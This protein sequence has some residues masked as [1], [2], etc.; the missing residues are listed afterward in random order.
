MEPVT[1][2]VTALALGAAAGLKDTAE[3]AIKDGYAALKSLVQHKY[4][5]VDLAQLEKAP[6]STARRAVVTEELEAAGAVRDQEILRQAQKLI[7]EITAQAPETAAAIGV[8][9]EDIKAASLTIEDVIASGTGAKVKKA[10]VAG[11]VTIKGIR[12][13]QGGGTP[14][15]K[16]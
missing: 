7:D 4:A 1:A 5:K 12:A 2:I 11:D 13:G 6:E 9:L 15:K 3:R 14:P 8:D 16:A 10:E